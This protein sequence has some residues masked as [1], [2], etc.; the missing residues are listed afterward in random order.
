M[1]RRCVRERE[2]LRTFTISIEYAMNLSGSELTVRITSAQ[3]G[4]RYR[5]STIFASSPSKSNSCTPSF[6]PDDQHADV[7]FHQNEAEGCK[8]SYWEEGLCKGPRC[9]IGSLVV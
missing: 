8:G 2:L 4:A 1:I 3:I 9:S 6:A 7:I 5:V